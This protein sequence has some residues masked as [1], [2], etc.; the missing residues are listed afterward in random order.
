[1][2]SPCG[3]I[4]IQLNCR[5]LSYSITE[6]H[7][8]WEKSH[9]HLVSEVWVLSKGG[10]EEKDWVFQHRHCLLPDSS[11]V[12]RGLG[13]QLHS[14]GIGVCSERLDR[15]GVAWSS[16]V[17]PKE[18]EWARWPTGMLEKIVTWVVSWVFPI[19]RPWDKD[20]SA[21]SFIWKVKKTPVGGGQGWQ[22]MK[23][24][25]S[26]GYRTSLVVQWL[27]L[28]AP[29]AGGRGSIPGQETRSHMLQLRVHMA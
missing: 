1:M 23:S 17:V 27:R 2:L 14:Q 11:L 29:S 5:T 28:L 13:C 3:S 24:A 21:S 20:L 9:T 25:L 22:S 18:E 19:R 6:N 12:S 16:A 8:V 15:H 10:I 7:L 4:R 26:A